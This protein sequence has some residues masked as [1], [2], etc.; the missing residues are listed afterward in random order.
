MPNRY[1]QFVK[2]FSEKNNISWNCAVC[3]IKENNLYKP[4]D[5]KQQKEEEK[6]KDEELSEKILLRSINSFKKRYANIKTYDDFYFVKS[7][8]F[9]R[10]KEFQEKVKIKT[11]KFFEQISADYEID[12]GETEEKIKTITIKKKYKKSKKDELKQEE[13]QPKLNNDEIYIKLMNE[14]VDKYN[15]IELKKNIIGNTFKEKKDKA[16]IIVK[17]LEKDLVELDKVKKMVIN[18]DNINIVDFIKKVDKTLLTKFTKLTTKTII[19]N[20]NTIIKS[21]P[22]EVINK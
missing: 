11:P 5:K 3:K 16:V 6:K 19:K 15:L 17:Q 12:D 18:D 10:S 13:I 8:F 14:Y 9:N 20:M 7:A 1:I 4:L 22:K 21:K 2:D